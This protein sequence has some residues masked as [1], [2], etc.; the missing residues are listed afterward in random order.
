MYS[1]Y[2]IG[3]FGMH[4]GRAGVLIYMVYIYTD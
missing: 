1:I 4:V 2:V 3:K